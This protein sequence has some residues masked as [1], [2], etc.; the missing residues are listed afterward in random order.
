M[1]KKADQDL[2]KE[3]GYP[4]REKLDET[5]RF[6]EILR[7]FFEEVGAETAEE[8]DMLAHNLH[9]VSGVCAF[10]GEAATDQK[11]VAESTI[12]GFSVNICE[13][14]NEAAKSVLENRRARKTVKESF[15]DIP[16]S[17]ELYA[18]LEGD[19]IGQSEA[20]RS[21][22][23]HVAGHYLRHHDIKARKHHKILK[24]KG[25][26][27]VEVRKSNVML[28]GP[29]GV[30]KTEI[31]RSLA[32]KL[33]VPFAIGDATTITE[34]GY[35]GEDVENLLLK[36]LSNAEFNV[37]AAERGIVY[38]D[39]I[40][41]IRKTGGN[42][43]IT[44][45]VSGEGVQQSLLKILEGTTANVPP[46]G[47]RKHP[48]QQFI[49]LDT[50]NI[51]FIVG[52]AFN[53]L[54]DIIR[55]RLGKK[56]IGFNSQA[57]SA[58]EM[59]QEDREILHQV[60]TEDLEEFGMIPEFIGRVP[61]VA[62]LDPL[63]VNDLI[64]ILTEPRNALVKQERKKAMYHNADFLFT[65]DALQEIAERA[66]KKQIGA[67]GLKAVVDA[68]MEDIYFNMPSD[69]GGRVFVIDK[70]IV[71]GVKKFSQQIQAA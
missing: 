49:Q 20:K 36:L 69:C 9:A 58:D 63:S 19:V 64:R 12:L 31:A 43:S 34:A 56:Q 55:R 50:T 41:K 37:E 59:V 27:Q 30:G 32:K 53:G 5:L 42:V 39:E 18:H 67:R 68:F 33:N 23:V 10:C 29:T 4:N 60:Q 51:L 16:N 24:E 40:D 26:D 22:A 45:D 54:A 8:Q 6:G 35:V 3:L 14:C 61:V 7:S 57:R 46:Q 25:L 66:S 15:F 38:I 71:T 21:I 70:E 28:I 65:D 1:A 52:G 48:E 44:R 13:V 62:T 17:K 47:G 2:I 11:P